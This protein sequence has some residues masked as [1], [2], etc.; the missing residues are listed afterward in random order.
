MIVDITR[1]ALRKGFVAPGGH[2]IF[3]PYFP[4]ANA[5]FRRTA[6]VEVGGFDERCR[7][8][9]DVDVCLR[10]ADS[11]YDLWYQPS[12][13]VIHL[14]RTSLRQLLALQRTF[15]PHLQ[16]TESLFRAE[17]LAYL[18]ELQRR[19]AQLGEAGE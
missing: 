2:G 12:A 8:G 15:E 16:Q 14:H 4:T 9:E 10:L 1:K 18:E 11:G 7:T 13:S 19:L 6:L 17:R 3:R 5:A